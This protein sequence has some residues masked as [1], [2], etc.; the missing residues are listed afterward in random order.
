MIIG[1]M[2][3][4]NPLDIKVTLT[5]TMPFADWQA[6][7]EKLDSAWPHWC[8]ASVIRAGLRDLEKISYQ[9]QEYHSP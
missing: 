2:R 4:E 1:K 3:V 5:L 8:L 6:I 9:E 7:A